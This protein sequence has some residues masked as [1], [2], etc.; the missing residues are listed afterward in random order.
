MDTWRI[1]NPKIQDFTFYFP[2]HGTYSRLDYI[3]VDHRFLYRI[4]E[5]KIEMTTL[6]DHAPVR[7]K[8]QVSKIQR[9]SLAWRLNEELLHDEI[10]VRIVEK[11]LKQYFLINETEEISGSSLGEAHKAYIRGILLKIGARKKKREK[12]ENGRT[13]LKTFLK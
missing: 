13:L 8:M 11:E 7:M 12:R 1:M 2:V 6:S 9:Y 3:L 10:S 5:S 4:V